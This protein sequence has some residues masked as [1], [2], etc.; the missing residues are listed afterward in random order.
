MKDEFCLGPVPC[1][2][3]CAQVGTPGYAPRAK[4]ECERYKQLLTKLFGPPPGKAALH[5]KSSDHDFGPYYEV[6]ASFE[7]FSEEECTWASKVEANL[8]THWEDQTGTSQGSP[9]PS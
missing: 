2:E 7:A 4:I 8:P 6:Y 1:E 3:E 9:P 5:V